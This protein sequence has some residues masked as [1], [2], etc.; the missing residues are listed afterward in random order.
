ML[1]ASI[2]V[3]CLSPLALGSTDYLD[4]V[5]QDTSPARPLILAYVVSGSEGDADGI[6]TC[7]DPMRPCVHVRKPLL[8]LN[9]E[10][11][12]ETAHS[13][14]ETRRKI[15]SGTDPVYEETWR[16]IGKHIADEVGQD[17]SW[18]WINSATE[19]WRDALSLRVVPVDD[20]GCQQDGRK[21]TGNWQEG[22]GPHAN[23]SE[24]IILR[25][26]QLGGVHR[27]LERFSM[28]AACYGSALRTAGLSEQ[29][30][31][32]IRL[33]LCSVSAAARKADRAIGGIG[34]GDGGGHLRLTLKSEQR[35]Q[36]EVGCLSA[37][38][39]R[40]E[41]EE[42]E[43]PCIS[44]TGDDTVAQAHL[45]V[46]VS[47]MCDEWDVGGALKHFSA[48][49]GDKMV[50]EA[51]L[52]Q[53]EN[54]DGGEQFADG[55]VVEWG[56][57]WLAQAIQGRS[58]EASSG[59]VANAT[60]FGEAWAGAHLQTWRRH[61]SRKCSGLGMSSVIEGAESRL[62]LAGVRAITI[63][64]SHTSRNRG[65]LAL[66]T[67]EIV[68]HHLALSRA[69]L[70]QGAFEEARGHARAAQRLEATAPPKRASEN[71]EE[72]ELNGG[73]GGDGGRN[74]D[75]NTTPG[76]P[77]SAK[78]ATAALLLEILLLS[79]TPV[80]LETEKSALL[81]RK[82]LM[83]DLER[84]QTSATMFGGS[85]STPMDV[86]VRA[87]FLSTYQGLD[88]K[89]LASTLARVFDL[90]S[91]RALSYYSPH[92]VSKRTPEDAADLGHNDGAQTPSH[93][94]GSKT[95][96]TTLRPIYSSPRA[97]EAIAAEAQSSEVHEV[98]GGGAVRTP[99][100]GKKK[101]VVT[102]VGFL[103]AH[104]QWHSVGR[105]TVALLEE[106]STSSA[107]EIFV[108][109]ASRGSR[110]SGEVG[111]PGP[112][113]WNTPRGDSDE[114]SIMERLAAAGASIPSDAAKRPPGWTE[115]SREIH[116]GGA[117]Y[118]RLHNTRETVAALELDV[119]VY[120]DVG[121]DALTTALAHSRLSPVQVAFWGHPGTTGLPT[122]DYFV[123]SDLFEADLGAGE[124]DSR[125]RTSHGDC[126][127]TANRHSQKHREDTAHTAPE[128]AADLAG[129][130]D[131]D[132]PGTRA[133]NEV[134]ERQ[135]A[136][137]EQLVR[138]GGLGFIFD[139]P[140]R[141]FRWVPI[142]TDSSDKPQKGATSRETPSD[143]GKKSVEEG[144]KETA[145]GYQ[146][147]QRSGGGLIGGAPRP[148]PSSG[149]AAAAAAYSE[150]AAQIARAVDPNRPR[151]YVCAQ[152]L[153]KMHPAFDA[154]LVGILAADPLAQVVLLRDSRQLLWH[155]RF[156]R[157]LRAAVDAAERR[158][159]TRLD[160]AASSTTGPSGGGVLEP[161][162]IRESVVR[163]GVFSPA[164]PRRRGPGPVPFRRRSDH[165]RG[166]RM[167]DPRCDGR[168]PPERSP[169]RRV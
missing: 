104:F 93:R 49:A 8:R 67:A 140:M 116:N 136:Y 117:G 74:G 90:A 139:D 37:L 29:Q 82:E 83:V 167:R 46:G 6:Y 127:T 2:L 33:S 91:G 160:T 105:L 43:T 10:A 66:I 52:A 68:D 125:A 22:K 4:P 87:Q 154:V 58:G 141:T 69:L 80:V 144:G 126:I 102:R 35:T 132:G 146:N 84:L 23:T 70:L 64:A 1:A 164:V 24:A 106:L 100:D 155:S 97:D 131:L 17:G 101:R 151:L 89:V 21:K 109:D 36:E 7:T 9:Q 157:R 163:E 135:D 75:Q 153:M 122:V 26:E 99:N 123:T 165:A 112:A 107:L 142:E 18:V 11:S 72:H 19:P 150:A 30:Q 44:M 103:S 41:G 61:L 14:R 128:G 79:R 78:S 120:G 28:S 166:S 145:K 124:R 31:C 38:L 114:R 148:S 62:V 63:E 34:G 50:Q 15:L 73:G 55:D 133:W 147:L 143:V 149:G 39:L 32:S 162:A 169:Q 119:L 115:K 130:E 118:H 111:Q 12:P 5:G 56:A 129:G 42:A 168:G 137:S 57:V 51:V 161:S 92:L 86:G 71:R 110:R 65:E 96:Q 77:V 13:R 113:D 98:A 108:I 16:Q 3:L 54:R 158:A 47:R 53:E 156:R 138:L 45:T 40:Q 85:I 121:M 59:F 27:H 81:L 152:S 76:Q 60:V 94:S 88:D 159:I 20:M 134:G 25:D 95:V 48:A